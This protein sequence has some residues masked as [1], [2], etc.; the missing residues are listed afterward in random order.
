MSDDFGLEPHEDIYDIQSL[1]V[2]NLT[3]SYS[4]N[5]ISLNLP[6]IKGLPKVLKYLCSQGHME[7]R[8]NRFRLTFKG[9]IDWNN[10]TFRE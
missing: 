4:F 10:N 2:D 8:N 7:K 9:A 1:L 6:H 3:K 5:E